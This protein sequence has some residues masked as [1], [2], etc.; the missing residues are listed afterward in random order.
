[1]LCSQISSTKFSFSLNSQSTIKTSLCGSLTSFW[2]ILWLFD[3]HMYVITWLNDTKQISNVSLTVRSLSFQVLILSVY[4]YRW[5]YIEFYSR[6]S[7]LM[8]QSELKLGEKKQTCRTVLQKLIPVREPR[9]GTSESLCSSSMF[10]KM[11][12]LV[13]Y[14]IPTS[15]SLVGLRSSSGRD[16]WRTWRSC[17]WIIFAGL[18]WPFRSTWGAGGRDAGS[19]TWD[20]LPS[21]YNSMC[22]ERNRSGEGFQSANDPKLDLLVQK[23]SN[24]VK[25]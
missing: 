7:I 8:S 11:S 1:M 16:R 17:V 4:P 21:R 9:C 14:R 25:Y 19:C 5:T 10:W 15:T 2:T 24:I 18:V 6:Y 12:S 23:Y 3:L 22:G 13:R 20:K